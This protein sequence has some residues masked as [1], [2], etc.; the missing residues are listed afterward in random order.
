[1]DNGA[2]AV[3]APPF[4]VVAHVAHAIV[5]VDVIVPPV[6]GEV[7]VID[8]TVPAPAPAF[9]VWL[10]IC[11][12]VPSYSIVA[13]VPAR[14][15]LAAKLVPPPCFLIVLAPAPLTF[16]V[17]DPLFAWLTA[18]NITTSPA[19]GVNDGLVEQVY[20]VAEDDVSVHVSGTTTS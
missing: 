6:I 2:V 7:V 12:L 16:S 13:A 19:A 10:S 11:Q 8:V 4:V 3:S 17:D 1:M 14:R 9:P 18:E 15:S 20:V 5:P